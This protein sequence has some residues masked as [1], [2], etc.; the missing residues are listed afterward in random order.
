MFEFN[1]IKRLPPYVFAIVNH[2]KM[3][4]RR[5]GED[6]IDLGMGNPDLPTPKHIVDKLC[7]AA[8]NPKNHRYS[9]SKGI[10]QLRVAITE[11]YKRRYDVDL[12]PETETCVTIGSK[13]GLSHLT[14]A[15]I[16]PGDVVVTPAPAYPIHPYAVIIAG[17]EVQQVPIGP[18]IDYFG[19]MEKTLRKTWPKP[20]MLIINFPHNPTTQCLDGLDFFQKIVDFAKEN[21]I[22]VIHDFAYADLVFDGYKPPSFLQVPGAK[23]VGVEFFSMTKSYSMAGW[24]VGFCCGNKEIVGALIKIKSYLDYGMF[25]PIQIASIVALRGPQDCVE[26]MRQTYESRRNVLIKGLNGAGWNIEPPRGTMFVWAEIPEPFRKLGSLEFAK[27]LIKE[28]KV[29]VSPGIGFGE[30]GDNFVRFALVENE[31]RIRQAVKGIKKAIN[32]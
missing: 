8:H 5:A 6:I 1:R 22:I 12:E 19:E 7:E 25:Q 4:A 13:E 14:L 3:E 16:Q 24:R 31:H 26:E 17:G 32:K 29:A 11:W 15:M 2:L 9:A 21:N 28:A 30:G 20:K 23:D 18:G 10:T 27:Y